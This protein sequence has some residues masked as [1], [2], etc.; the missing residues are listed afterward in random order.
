MFKAMMLIWLVVLLLAVTVVSFVTR[1]ME[2][3][4]PGNHFSNSLENRS[5]KWTPIFKDSRAS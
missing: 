4:R 1:L 2:E 5:K 3:R